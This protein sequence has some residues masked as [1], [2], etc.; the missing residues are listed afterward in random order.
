VSIERRGE[1]LNI[2]VENSSDQL[3]AN[4]TGPGVGLQNVRR[5]LEICYGPAATLHLAPVSGK[6]TAEIT[7]PLTAR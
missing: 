1:Q 6:T 5:R 4:V 2:V 7:I 3:N